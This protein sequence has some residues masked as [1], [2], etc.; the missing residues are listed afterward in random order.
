MGSSS[1]VNLGF[2][3]VTTVDLA[4]RPQR[5][6]HSTAKVVVSVS[7][8]DHC[9]PA[10]GSVPDRPAT[11]RQV[12]ASGADHV[13][14]AGVFGG[15]DTRSAVIHTYGGNHT[16]TVTLAVA[17]PPRPE[18]ETE[19]VDVTPTVTLWD[20]EGP[21]EPSQEPDAVHDFARVDDQISVTVGALGA[22]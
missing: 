20:P 7:G 15:T 16:R 11:P 8:A 10:V 6:L 19:Y 4:A 13:S 5:L 17:T 14:S 1:A 12:A 21:S 2:T 22:L 3:T 18:Q 9:N